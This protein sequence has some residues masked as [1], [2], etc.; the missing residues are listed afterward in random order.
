M[1]AWERVSDYSKRTGCSSIL[2]PAQA[3]AGELLQL[4]QTL[5]DKNGADAKKQEE[6]GAKERPGTPRS[7]G[8]YCEAFPN[9]SRKG[10]VSECC[11]EATQNVWSEPELN[12][13]GGMLCS[14]TGKLKKCLSLYAVCFLE[15]LC[16]QI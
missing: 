3:T 13:P 16:T 9:E 11:V 2:P 4:S 5:Q 12:T 10:R 1:V 6:M 7:R 15:Y 8:M 14:C